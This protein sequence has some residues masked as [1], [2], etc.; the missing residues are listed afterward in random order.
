M[1]ETR[2]NT[3]VFDRRELPRVKALLIGRESMI[4]KGY[5][6]ENINR[7]LSVGMRECT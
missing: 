6:I 1:S 7:N 5:V 3:K 2:M 4:A